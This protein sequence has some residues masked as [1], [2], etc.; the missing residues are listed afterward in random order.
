MSKE[1]WDFDYDLSIG[2]VVHLAHACGF[3]SEV[4]A[5]GEGWDFATFVCDGHVVRVP[6]RAE[7][8]ETLPRELA[9]L[10]SLPVDLSLQTPRPWPDLVKVA[11][12][13][14][15]CMVYPYLPGRPL[16]GFDPDAVSIEPNRSFAEHIGAQ[17]GAFLGTVHKRTSTPPAATATG[18]NTF[19]ADD[20]EWV[21]DSIER[22]ESLRSILGDRFTH[23]LKLRVQ[24]RV[25]SSDSSLLVCHGDLHAEHILVD[26]NDAVAVIDWGDVSV[27]PW[28]LDFVGL[29]MW[30][31]DPCLRFALAAYGRE[32]RD[33]EQSHLRRRALMVAI[34]DCDY[35]RTLDAQSTIASTQRDSTQGLAE[36]VELLRRFV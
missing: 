1:D 6:K 34:L 17:V 25:P 3:E 20:A 16:D 4:E 8:A 36:A 18:L 10:R 5:L 29:W 24:Q 2:D 32:A 14:Y 35:L 26:G 19:E 9:F 30:G 7:T 13:P 27:G 15:P 22:L 23:Q 21:R 33:H 28:W 12:L 11:A 31:G